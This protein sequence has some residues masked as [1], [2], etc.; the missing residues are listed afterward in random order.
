MER[1]TYKSNLSTD[2]KVLMGIVRAAEIF[3]RAHAGVFKNHGLSFP[4]YNVLRVLEASANGRNMIGEVG[5]IML[6]PGANMTGIAKRLE[7]GGFILRKSD[8]R[9]ERVTMLEITPKGKR[10]LGNIQREKDD[11]VERMLTGFSQEEKLQL[12]RM[13]KRLIK[14][15]VQFAGGSPNSPAQVA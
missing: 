1:S 6:V 14:K 3:K 8:R 2:E 13:V 7:K 9:D 5:R 12:L 15:S 11:W 4:Q 10:T